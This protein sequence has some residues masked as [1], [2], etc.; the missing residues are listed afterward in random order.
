MRKFKMMALAM[1][2]A[3]TALQA[4]EGAAATRCEIECYRDY[5]QCL[6][7]CSKNPCLV[8]CETVLQLC[9]NNC[10]SEI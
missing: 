6:V 4:S 3:F 5:E 2:L 7:I 10:G 1:G 8:S 9:L